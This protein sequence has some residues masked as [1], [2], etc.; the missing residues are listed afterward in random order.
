M[1]FGLTGIFYYKTRHGVVNHLNIPQSRLPALR[2][3]YSPQVCFLKLSSG[4]PFV[5]HKRSLCMWSYAFPQAVCRAWGRFSPQVCAFDAWGWCFPP[6]I[7]LFGNDTFTNCWSL[8]SSTSCTS[9]LPFPDKVCACECMQSYR[10]SVMQGVDS[11]PVCSDAWGW[12]FPPAISLFRKDNLH[13]FYRAWGR[14]SPPVCFSWRRWS[15]LRDWHI[16]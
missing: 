6:A 11:S 4:R 16:G 15:W 1:C 12:R 13:H 3:V 10:P 7:W 14:R 8:S 2:G 5:F 9:W